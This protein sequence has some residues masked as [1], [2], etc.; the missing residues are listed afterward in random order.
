VVPVPPGLRILAGVLP[1]TAVRG[2][3][4]PPLRGWSGCNVWCMRSLSGWRRP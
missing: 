3:T 2:F 4:I 1:R